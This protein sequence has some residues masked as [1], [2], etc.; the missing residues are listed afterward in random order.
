MVLIPYPKAPRI[1][2][3]YTKVKASNEQVLPHALYKHQAGEERW[4]GEER[5]P[6]HGCGSNLGGGANHM[7]T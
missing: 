3:K 7:N 1:T 5:K 4:E 2:Q 6:R